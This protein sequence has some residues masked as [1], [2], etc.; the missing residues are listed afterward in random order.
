MLTGEV[1]INEGLISKEQLQMAQ[2]KQREVGGTEPIA[3]LL[4]SMGFIEERDRVRCLGKVWGIPY[5]D[6]QAQ[7]PKPEVLPLISP[8]LAKRYKTIP[9]DRHENKLVVAMANPPRTHRPAGADSRRVA[10]CAT[11]CS[12]VRRA[13]LCEMK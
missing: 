2:D 4:V 3:R 7:T 8:Q 9:L 13:G 11:R 5:V 12:K 1:F 6:L 10:R